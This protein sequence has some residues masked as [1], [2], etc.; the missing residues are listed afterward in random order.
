MFALPKWLKS[1]G[2]QAQA[3]IAANKHAVIHSSF[4]GNDPTGWNGV[5]VAKHDAGELEKYI[6]HI[7]AATRANDFGKRRIAFGP[8]ANAR[9]DARMNPILAKVLAQDLRGTNA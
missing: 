7:I 6:A 3:N 9:L 5:D 4:F 1:S 2:R 8:C